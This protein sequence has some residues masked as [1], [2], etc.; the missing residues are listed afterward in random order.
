MSSCRNL[1]A[2]L[3]AAGACLPAPL[4]AS[5]A[6]VA[7][8]TADAGWNDPAEATHIHGNA[9][10]VGTCGISAILITSAQG[11]VLIDGATEKAAPMIEANIRALGFKVEDVKYLLNSH[12][13]LDHAGGLA[14]LQHDSGARLFAREPAAAALE[15]GRG[16]RRDPQFLSAGKFPP[17]APATRISDGETLKLGDFAIT[18][19]ATPGHTPGSTSWTWKSCE[20]DRCLDLV[21]ADSLTPISDDSYRFSDE[22]SHP[23][24]LAAFRQS[25]ARVTAFPCDVLLTP[26][27]GAS[28]LWARIGKGATRPLVD[29]GRCERYAAEARSRLD[30]RIAAEIGKHGNSP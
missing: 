24:H 25:I 29:P 6:A 14:Q 30:A 7:G 10:Y 12:E 18:A 9:W 5:E 23:G 16:D 27:P 26:H 1:P 21:Y 17:T 11:H 19:H 2:W 22:A 13:H 4:P 3:L 28:E 20:G 8:C 15:R